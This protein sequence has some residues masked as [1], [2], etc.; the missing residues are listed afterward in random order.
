MSYVPFRD[1]PDLAGLPEGT[2]D[3]LVPLADLIEE[4]HGRG[5]HEDDCA[6][7]NPNCPIL[8][9]AMIRIMPPPA[10]VV[11]GWL[12]A[13]GLLNLDAAHKAGWPT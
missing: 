11:M 2:F 9:R 3:R 12:V 8:E 6:C 4:S 1:N 13:K 5:I 10:E 7:T